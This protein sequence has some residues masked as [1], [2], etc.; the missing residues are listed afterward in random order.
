MPKTNGYQSLHTTVIG[1]QGKP[2]EIQVR[3]HAMHQTAEFG[4]AAHWLYKDAQAAGAAGLA[5]RRGRRRRRRRPAGV[6]GRAARRPL[7]RGGLRLHAEGRAQG[8]AR[9]RDAARLRVRRAHR[10]RPPLRR[11]EGQR[12]HR[13]A[14][15]HAAVGR[16]RRGAHVEVRARPVARL[17]ER[18]ARRPAP[19]TRSAQWFAKRAA[20]GP[21]AEGPRLA[22][23]GAQAR[24]ACRTRRSPP[25]RCWPQLIREMGFK[26]AEDFYVAIGGGKVPVGQV[27]TRSCSG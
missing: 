19:A 5:A 18:R 27:V 11:R 14:A 21:R 2:L 12:P 4:V 15:L 8:A 26:K 20:R 13:A 3:T 9:R 16:H 24:T 23:P 25:R 10:R 7:R 6:H 17:A 22:A 1:P